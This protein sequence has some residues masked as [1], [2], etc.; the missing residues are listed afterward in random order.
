MPR[1]RHRRMEFGVEQAFEGVGH[2]RIGM[3]PDAEPLRPLSR[4]VAE[5][6]NTKP[7]GNCP[8]AAARTRDGDRNVSEIVT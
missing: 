2:Q 4:G 5:H 3:H 8:S 6:G 1:E 7:R